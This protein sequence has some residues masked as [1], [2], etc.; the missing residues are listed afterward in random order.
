METLWAVATRD[1]QR[2]GLDT[3]AV[4]ALLRSGEI[5][6]ASLV[7]R[8]GWPDW[9]PLR[10]VPE[11]AGALAPAPGF[12]ARRDPASTPP[13]G[14]GEPWFYNVAPGRALLLWWASAGFYALV[15]AYRHRSWLERRA[16]AITSP[17]WQF[18]YDRWLPAEVASA[19]QRV[20]VRDRVKV[21]LAPINDA[22]LVLSA[23]C[24]CL[25]PIVLGIGVLRLTE[26]QKAAEVVNQAVAPGAARPPM[27]VGEWVSLVVGLGVWIGFP[28]LFGLNLLLATVE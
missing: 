22:L 17:F 26:L 4:I 21:T 3:A 6:P 11:L 15:W 7:W 16:G 1:G 28:L 14:P 25:L 19:A 20:G 27:D 9:V 24:C 23:L 8:E 18:R 10:Q 13:P 12:G 2:T 5:T